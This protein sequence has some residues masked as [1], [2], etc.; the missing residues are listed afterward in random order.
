MGSG[1]R[2]AGP[3]FCDYFPEK[4]GYMGNLYSYQQEWDEAEAM[5]NKGINLAP[6]GKFRDRLEVLGEVSLL[7]KDLFF[8]PEPLE[9]EQ[10][11]ATETK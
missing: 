7:G 1:I 9:G 2:L 4:A 10:W 11:H 6:P 5:I 3:F 8:S